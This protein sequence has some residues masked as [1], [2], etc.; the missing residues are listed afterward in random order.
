MMVELGGTKGG[1]TGIRTRPDT[2]S[3]LSPK[4]HSQDTQNHGNIVINETKPSAT[5]SR[6]TPITRRQIDLAP[7]CNHRLN[8]V[9][10]IDNQKLFDRRRLLFYTRMSQATRSSHYTIRHHR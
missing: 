5:N 7:G 10:S 6:T 4:R 8:S 1:P 9:G 2:Y 3:R